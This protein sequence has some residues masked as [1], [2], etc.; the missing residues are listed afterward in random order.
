M[1]G[2]PTEKTKFVV[3][4]FQSSRYE[5]VF[6]D[7]FSYFSLKPYVVIPHLNHLVKT[8]QM[9]GHNICFYAELTKIIAH[10]EECSNINA[11]RQ[12]SRF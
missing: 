4:Y 3:K 7:N 10:Y 5:G 11:T 2:I 8:I 9:R 12:I 1:C 6:D